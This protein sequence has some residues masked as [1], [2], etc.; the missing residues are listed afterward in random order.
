M[1]IVYRDY[2]ES[3]Y[4]FFQACVKNSPE[5]QITECTVQQLSDYI[6][7]YEYLNG[8][9]LV[10]NY[11]GEPIGISY[12]VN[13]SPAN[14]RPWIGTILVENGKRQKGFGSRIVEALSREWEK[15]G[16]KVIYTAIPIMQNGWSEFL[17]KCSF[18]Q[19]KI[20][21][22]NEITYLLFVKP[23]EKARF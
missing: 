15:S 3:D 17:S 7:S 21:K 6:Q 12:T 16:H 5:W 18:E 23:L 13:E 19:Y 20:E 22:E 10:W 4:E 11:N 9:W 2:E 1:D 8:R 14:G